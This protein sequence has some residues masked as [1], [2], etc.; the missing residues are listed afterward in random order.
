MVHSK[1]YLLLIDTIAQEHKLTAFIYKSCYENQ[2]L[3]HFL[4]A[5]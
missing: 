1:N 4:Q 2:E 3:L 5:F